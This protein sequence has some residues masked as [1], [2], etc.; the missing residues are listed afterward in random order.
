MFLAG[1]QTDALFGKGAREM[2]RLHE[3]A[4]VLVW[5]DME[6]LRGDTA[7]KHD[8]SVQAVVVEEVELDAKGAEA[9]TGHVAKDEEAGV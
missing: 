3:T 9:S 2:R 6:G 5:E 4:K 8:G 1:A 7:D